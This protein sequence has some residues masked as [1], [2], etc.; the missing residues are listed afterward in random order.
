MLVRLEIRGQVV[1]L[2]REQADYA[3]ALAEA[4]SGRSSRLRDLALVL[5]WALASPRVVSLR[6]SEAR[7]LQRLALE[8][9]ALAEVAEAIDGA[10]GAAA[11]A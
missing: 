2:R 8:T 11:A 4:Q 7:E 5:E 3:R 10:S 6:R 9:P 1:V